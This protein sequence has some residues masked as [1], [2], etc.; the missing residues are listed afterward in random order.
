PSSLSCADCH[1]DCLVRVLHPFPTRRSSDLHR[2]QFR[3]YCSERLDHRIRARGRKT[4]RFC[5]ICGHAR[6]DV[7]CRNIVSEMM[8]EGGNTM[9]WIIMRVELQIF[10]MCFTETTHPDN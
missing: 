1:V 7:K 2:T 4:G 6:G 3:F 8:K 9:K 10:L 5:Y